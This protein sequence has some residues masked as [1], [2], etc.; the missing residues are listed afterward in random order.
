MLTEAYCSF[1]LGPECPLSAFFILFSFKHHLFKEASLIIQFIPS[2]P[3]YLPS[4]SSTVL[5]PPRAE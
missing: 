2:I 1:S 3:K 4:G 5:N